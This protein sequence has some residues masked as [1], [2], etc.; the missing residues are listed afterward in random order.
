[1]DCLQF[2]DKRDIILKTPDLLDKI[3]FDEK[4][5][6]KVSFETS[7]KL[8]NKLAHAQ[9]IIMGS[10]WEK[11]IVLVAEIEDILKKCEVIKNSA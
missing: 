7:E 9:D 6:G 8:R 5:H 3:G 11:V 2:C 1:M 10:T 4:K